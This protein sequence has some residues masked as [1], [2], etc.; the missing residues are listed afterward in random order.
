CGRGMAF[1]AS[2]QTVTARGVCAAG[3]L[4]I[5]GIGIKQSHCEAVG[6]IYGK[7]A[8]WQEVW[9]NVLV[10]LG[11]CEAG[12]ALLRYGCE[13]VVG[14]HDHIGRTVKVKRFQGGQEGRKIV[15]RIADRGKRGRPV[16][17]GNQTVQAVTLV[18]LGSVRIARPK[19]Q[20]ERLGA[21]F[22]ERQNCASGH[23][24]E[25]L[26]L[27]SVR[28]EGAGCLEIARLAVLTTRRG[29]Q[30]EPR[31]LEPLLHLLAERDTAGAPG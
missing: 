23:A 18:M 16:D 11:G 27:E 6:D 30:V 7:E 17:P 10:R 4:L 19:H 15:V 5:L 20:H 3:N 14:G 24:Y 1:V 21:L 25:V 8:R 31:G 29:L 2:D 22:E 26:L 12:G 13:A 28:L 9:H